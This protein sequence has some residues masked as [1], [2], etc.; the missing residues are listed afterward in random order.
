MYL[1]EK[2]VYK[3]KSYDMA[4]VLPLI[5]GVSEKPQGHGYSILEVVAENPFFQPGSILKGHEFHYSY[6][7]DVIEK[8]DVYFACKAKRGNGIIDNLEGL[9]YRN[10]F[11]TYTHLHALGTE[12]WVS[13]ILR[14][15][16]NKKM[17]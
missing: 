7:L 3:G 9:C 10:V 14:T 17:H 8:K 16:E 12:Q 13:G 1:G 4:G 2:L 6:I 5:V 11:A 15:T